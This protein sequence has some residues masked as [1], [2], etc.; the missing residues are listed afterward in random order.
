MRSLLILYGVILSMI[1]SYLA[2]FGQYLKHGKCEHVNVLLL[3]AHGCFS[4]FVPNLTQMSHGKEC[5]K[6]AQV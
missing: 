1:H 4:M 6:T 2:S 5:L 3:L